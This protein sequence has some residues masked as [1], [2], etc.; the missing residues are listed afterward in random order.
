MVPIEVQQWRQNVILTRDLDIHT[1]RAQFFARARKGEF[2]ALFRGVWVPTPLWISLSRAEQYELRVKAA[3]AVDPAATFSHESAAVLWRLPMVG[4]WSVR[5]QTLAEELR[6]GRS[7]AMFQ[8]HA[9]GVPL[10]FE[11]IQGIRVTSLARTV[12]DIARS[13]PFGVAV[14]MTD[15]ALRCSAHPAPGAPPV[16]LS[17]QSLLDELQFIPM[18]HGTAKARAVIEFASGLA[19]RP[20]ESM[21]RVSMRRARIPAPELQVRLRGASGKTYFVDFFW[22]EADIIGEFDGAAKYRDPEFLRGRTPH[23]ALL[24]EKW[25]E[26]DLRAAGHGMSRWGWEVA[27]SPDRLRAQLCAAGVCRNHGEV[28]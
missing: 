19:D 12:V 4:A 9:A 6:G 28:R 18:R 2:T 27:T 23:A 13:L 21:S 7:N 24:D 22:R 16:S 14:T 15:A 11:C 8:R 10:E 20:G 17:Q 3:A 5:I 25:R 1:D 26:D